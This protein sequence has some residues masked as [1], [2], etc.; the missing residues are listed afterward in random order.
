MSES[1][2]AFTLVVIVAAIL[3]VSAVIIS[4]DIDGTNDL[5]KNAF[6]QIQAG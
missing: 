1:L 3:T 5:I 4:I 6:A 2:L